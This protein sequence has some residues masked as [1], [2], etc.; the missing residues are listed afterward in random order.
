MGFD[1]AF[2]LQFAFKRFSY[3]AFRYAPSTESVLIKHELVDGGLNLPIQIK[4][5]GSL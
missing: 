4:R 2:N 1:I 3:S 5:T